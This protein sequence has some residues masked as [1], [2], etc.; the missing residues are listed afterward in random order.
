[1]DTLLIIKDTIAVNFTNAAD[2]SKQ[3]PQEIPTNEYDYGIVFV[4]CASFFLVAVVITAGFYLWQKAK[5]NYLKELDAQKDKQDSCRK[6]KEYQREKERIDREDV[7]KEKEYQREKERIDREDVRKE[8]EY[9][10]EQERAE[11][12]NAKKDRDV[13]EAL[14]L[15]CDAAKDKDGMIDKDILTQL[16]TSFN[17]ARGYKSQSGKGENV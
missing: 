11:W 12:D 10:R 13:S 3:C 7:R 15:I 5:F 16:L 4:I 1:M 2:L 9:R 8:K 14:K 17:T 6:E